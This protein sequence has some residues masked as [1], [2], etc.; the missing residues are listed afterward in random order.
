MYRTTCG[1][2]SSYLSWER[3]LDTVNSF[4]CTKNG[5]SGKDVSNVLVTVRR[6]GTAFVDRR[7]KKLSRM[8]LKAFR[9]TD[10]KNV[11]IKNRFIIVEMK[12]N[13]FRDKG[14]N[15]RLRGLKTKRQL[16]MEEWQTKM[17]QQWLNEERS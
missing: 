5:V 6:I 7:K 10:A 11:P 13:Q 17:E 12:S 4:I 1:Y 14:S 2:Y 8:F 9:V 3:P 15:L 16:E